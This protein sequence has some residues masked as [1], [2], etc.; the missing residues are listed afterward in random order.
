MLLVLKVYTLMCNT[1]MVASHPVLIYIHEPIQLNYSIAWLISVLSL[2]KICSSLSVV[3]WFNRI[4]ICT[5]MTT[6][7]SMKT[8]NITLPIDLT[9]FAFLGDGLMVWFHLGLF[10]LWCKVLNQS[11]F[12]CPKLAINQNAKKHVLWPVQLVVF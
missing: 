7:I 6:F 3:A 9:A 5:N 10:T 11:L 8:I 2:N 12:C 1:L 4:T